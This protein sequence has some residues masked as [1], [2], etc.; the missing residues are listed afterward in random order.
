MLLIRHF[1]GHHVTEKR[2]VWD[3]P[4]RIFHWLFALSIFGSWATA[5]A[6]FE[7]M[8]FHFFLGYL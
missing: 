5:E 4:L 6:G 3:L 2:L 8:Q 7:W 1:T